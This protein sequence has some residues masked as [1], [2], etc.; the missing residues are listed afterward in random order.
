MQFHKKTSPGK[1]N[2]AI[3]LL[4]KILILSAVV[5]LL[6]VLIDKINFPYPNKKIEKVIPNE[7]F[8]TVK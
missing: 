7:T 1:S 2:I 3:K 4:I 5:F 8:K 6:V